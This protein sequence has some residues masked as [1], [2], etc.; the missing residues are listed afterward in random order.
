M[1]KFNVVKNFFYLKKWLSILTLDK[2]L[3][4]TLVI[5]L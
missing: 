2:H 1:K 3:C 4:K 5:E